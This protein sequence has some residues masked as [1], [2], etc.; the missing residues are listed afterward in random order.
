M[1]ENN[2]K[3]VTPKRTPRPNSDKQDTLMEP[4]L[5]DSSFAKK[6][7]GSDRAKDA[8]NSMTFSLNY[9]EKNMNNRKPN[10]EKTEPA[11]N[12]SMEETS[13][14]NVTM[15]ALDLEKESKRKI[16]Y[17]SESY[18]DEEEKEQLVTTQS[19]NHLFSMIFLNKKKQ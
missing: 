7:T 6:S 3:S 4:S 15:E 10:M 12:M 19:N 8:D 2:N 18:Q 14:P 5:M 17:A 13:S 9:F 16:I 1:Q 11:L